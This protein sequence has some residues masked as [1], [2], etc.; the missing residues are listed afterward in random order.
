MDAIKPNNVSARSLGTRD[1]RECEWRCDIVWRLC[2]QWRAAR[3]FVQVQR[4]VDLERVDVDAIDRDRPGRTLRYCYDKTPN[5]RRNYCWRLLQFGRRILYR[6][7]E[8]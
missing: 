6:H 7:V 1:E 5:V 2:R 8:L 4:H 3:T